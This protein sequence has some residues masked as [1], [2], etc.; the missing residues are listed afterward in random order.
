MLVR[1]KPAMS[2]VVACL[3]HLNSGSNKVVIKARRS[4]TCR[5]VDAIETLRRSFAKN[6]D[7]QNI[8]LSTEEVMRDKGQKSNVSAIEITLA[9]P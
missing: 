3:T 5:A 1:K 4:A 6:L 9:K 7:L 8:S 2:Y